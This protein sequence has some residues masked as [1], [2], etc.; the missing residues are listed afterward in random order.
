MTNDN[1]SELNRRNFL[2]GGSA[3]AF[4][5]L[6]GGVP[7]R[8]AD[9]A[10]DTGA[11][12][13]KAE[14]PPVKVGV[15]GCGTW[16][17]EIL[18]TLSTI[19]FGPVVGI[20]D[21]FPAYLKR[22]GNLAPEAKRYAD[23][24]ELLANADIQAVVV[25]T[26]S[27]LHKDL[28]L[29]A[30]QAGKHVYCE[31]PL[32]ASLEDARAI[33]AAAQKHLRLNFQAGLQARSDKQMVNLVKFI[34]TGV[35][36]TALKGSAQFHKKM[37]WRI[38]S[39]TPE[40]EKVLNWRLDNATSGGLI[41]ELGVHQ[42]DLANWFL[43]GLPTEAM[44]MGALTYYKD[45]RDVFDNVQALLR[46][47]NGLHYSYSA[48]IGNS[49]DGDLAMFFGTDCAI[50]VRERRAWMFKEADAPLLGWEVFARKDAFYKESGISLRAGAS[51]QDAQ[52]TGA[53]ADVVDPISALQ[54]S[55][56]SFLDNSHNL[57]I[58]VAEFAEAYGEGSDDDLREFLKEQEKNRQPAASWLDGY[59]ATVAA[60]EANRAVVTD[61]RIDL[62]PDLFTLG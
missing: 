18:K 32:A 11:T 21:T 13:Y 44:G 61:Q 48:T 30:L 7:I 4:F 40:R 23:P 49:F 57:A 9:A 3:A 31:A 17:R 6:L 29:A 38:A 55:L 37:S 58:G 54:Y 33:A 8:A 62:P 15:I 41:A 34:R 27:H 45:E 26:P 12:D 28:V 42:L 47:P 39:A 1:A 50:M 2:R 19:P 56:E 22:G 20:C 52:K 53:D 60:L 14:T 43:N 16:G 35:M 24:A 51:K 5:A 46:Y 25:A 36:G 59:Q 10:A